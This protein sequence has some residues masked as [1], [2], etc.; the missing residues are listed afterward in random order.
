MTPGIK[1]MKEENFLKPYNGGR[2]YLRL[3]KR[4]LL[5]ASRLIENSGKK[6]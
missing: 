6:I 1:V 4:Q 5:A 3:V 2:K